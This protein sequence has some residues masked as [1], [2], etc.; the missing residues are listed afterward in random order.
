LFVLHITREY[1]SI[2]VRENNLLSRVFRVDYIC[3]ET[4]EV[5]S[6]TISYYNIS[7]SFKQSKNSLEFT[8]SETP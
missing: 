3:F 5:D 2:F 6:F 8:I 1:E 7:R 4:I